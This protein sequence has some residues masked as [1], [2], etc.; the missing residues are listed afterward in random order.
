MRA[1]SR[2]LDRQFQHAVAEHQAGRLERAEADYRDIL[3]EAPDHA[4]ALHGLGLI[5]LQQ[6]RADLAIGYI[7]KAAALARDNAGYHLD[8]G[9][10]LRARGHLEEARAAVH[11]AVLLQ[12]TDADARGALADS[13]VLL[14]RLEEAA[15]AYRAALEL[16]PERPGLHNALGVVLKALG[17][18]EEAA[19]ALRQAAALAPDDAEVRNNLGA[20]LAELGRPDEAATALRA[21]LAARPDHP[22]ALNNLGT[23]LHTLGRVDEAVAVLQE[24][25]RLAPDQT[26]ILNNLGVALR[27]LGALDRALACFD[28]VLEDA[29]ADADARLNRATVLLL[30]GELTQG[31]DGLE[32]RDR[33]HGAVPREPGRPRWTGEALDGRTLLVRA[34][35]GLGDMIQFCR[36]VP[37]IIGGTIVVEAPRPLV[38]LLGGL[39]GAAG[40]VEQG[41]ALPAFDLECKVMSLPRLFGTTL[42]TIPARVPYLVADPGAVARWRGRVAALG[43]LAVGLCWAGSAVYQHDR[44]RSLD[45]RLLAPLARVPGVRLVSL[46]KDAPAHTAFAALTDWTSEL[47]DFADTAGLIAALDL[48]IT[49]D[50]AVAHLAGALGRPVWLLNRFGGDWRWLQNRTD[51]PWYPTLRQFRQPALNDWAHVVAQVAEALAERARAWAR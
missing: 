7:G 15:Q 20:T 50:T 49:A 38:R 10:A 4:D 51:S 9:L 21:A 36:Y 46:Q 45:P 6:D 23:V 8:L 27:D 17:Q 24:A 2:R 33:V 31:W 14:G 41:A 29:P 35:Q 44:R 1:R 28:A 26:D 22:G 43:G 11:V 3:R 37:L 18:N 25:R 40:I 48:V 42:E 39:P 5:A 12:P 34:E 16:A 13:L 19:Q 32:W 47:G 30:R